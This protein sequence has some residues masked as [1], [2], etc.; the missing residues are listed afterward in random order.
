MKRKNTHNWLPG[1]AS[2]LLGLMLPASAAEKF[3]EFE[4]QAVLLYNVT[5]FVEWPGSAFRGPDEPVTLCILGDDPFISSLGLLQGKPVRR[6]PI[7]LRLLEENPTPEDRCHIL[8][9]GRS[10]EARFEPVLRGL[11]TAPVLTIASFEAFSAHGGVL[12]LIKNGKRVSLLINSQ[13][14]RQA[15]LTVNSQLLELATV[16]GQTAN[17]G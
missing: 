10:E 15:G 6:R 7:A 4:V 14:S 2:L 11:G 17:G 13:A 3:T 9:V 1:L 16:V 5:K 12:S 8:F